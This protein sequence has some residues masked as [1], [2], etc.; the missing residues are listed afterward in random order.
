MSPA[1]TQLQARLDP[2]LTIA[3]RF[4]AR[5]PLGKG[6]D[7]LQP[8]SLA[9][10]YPQPMYSALAD[11]SP[12]WMLPGVDQMP[13]NAAVLL[14]TN[15]RFVEAFMVGLNEAFAGELIWREFPVGRSATYFQN[16]WGGPV[17]DIPT[18]DSFD[19]SGHLGDHEADHAT[20]GN[21]VLLI[22]AD[23]FSRYP[24]TVVSAVQATWNG[25]NRQ[26]SAAAARKWPLFRGSF[27]T[28]LN[29]FGFD[30]TDPRGPDA[31]SVGGAAGWYFVLEEHVTEPRFG[32]EPAEKTPLGTS[33]NDLRWSDVALDR[34]FL[35]P[36]AAPAPLNNVAWGQ[37]EA[38]WGQNAAAMAAILLRRPV[39]VAMHGRAL[40]AAAGT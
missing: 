18:I 10:Q 26:I 32:L 35:N 1:R 36:A 4:G 22:R 30:I 38:T 2:N 9:P 21:L 34:S 8:L 24:N 40:I 11:L 7:P 28:D 3:A 31:P 13:R 20:G 23:L 25:T 12:T 16:F 27:G 37:G 6:T 19:P 14:Q 17:P 29:F 5:I 15:P 33:W 39:R